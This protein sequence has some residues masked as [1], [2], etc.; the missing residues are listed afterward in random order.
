MLIFLGLMFCL[1]LWVLISSMLVLVMVLLLFIIVFFFVGGGDLIIFIYFFVLFCFFFVFFGL[2]IGS[3]FV[4]V[5]VS[6]ELMFGILVELMFIFLLLVLVLIVGFM[7][8]EMISNMLVMGWNLLLIIVLVLLVCGFVC[9]IEMGKIFF[10][11]VE[12]E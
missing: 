1:M 10:D 9:F 7:Y 5:G 2:D 12:V 8:I 6:C 3:L 11:V 4:G